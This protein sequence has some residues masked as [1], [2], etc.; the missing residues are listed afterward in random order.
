MISISKCTE[1]LN[2][3]DNKYT[4]EQIKKIREIL[5]FLAHIEYELNKI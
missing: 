2:K 5:M 1:I 4:E 3:N